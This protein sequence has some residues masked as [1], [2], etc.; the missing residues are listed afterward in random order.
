MVAVRGATAK[1]LAAGFGCMVHADFGVGVQ[2]CFNHSCISKPCLSAFGWVT[3]IF[4]LHRY[5]NDFTLIV[6]QEYQMT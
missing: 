4:I 3:Y 5:D 6:F 2:Q 1:L